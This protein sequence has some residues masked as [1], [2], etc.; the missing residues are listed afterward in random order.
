[1]EKS[2]YMQQ[3]NVNNRPFSQTKPFTALRM[4]RDSTF[5]SSSPEVPARQLAASYHPQHGVQ[6]FRGV[7]DTPAANRQKRVR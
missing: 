6:A 3:F 4:A 5:R 7:F 1:M 2:L